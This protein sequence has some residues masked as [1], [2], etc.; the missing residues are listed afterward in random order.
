[1]KKIKKYLG[2]R[3]VSIVWTLII[4]V[5]LAL[6]GSV[7]PKEQTFTI[8]QL[9]KFVHVIL[10][11]G[12]VFLWSYYFSKKQLPFTKLVRVFF[13]IFIAACVYGIGMEYVQK[14][15]IPMRDYDEADII[16]DILG[17]GMAYG[18]CTIWFLGESFNDHKK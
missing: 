5:L 10:F 9:D 13:Y 8:P 16:A 7:M 11:G 15:F 6:P 4:L 14:Y 18:L 1:M 12:F 17:A 3:W 2:R